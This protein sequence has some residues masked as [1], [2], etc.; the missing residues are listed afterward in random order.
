MNLESF[1][2]RKAIS[3]FICS[4]STAIPF[5]CSSKQ[6][7]R[8]NVSAVAMLPSVR[9]AMVAQQQKIAADCDVLM[10]GRDIGTPNF[11]PLR[12]DRQWQ[13]VTSLS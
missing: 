6:R 7:R 10:D 13:S 9:E 11:F 2:S 5:C 3:C 12:Q 8:A 1:S 4:K